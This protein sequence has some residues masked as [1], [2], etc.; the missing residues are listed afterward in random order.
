[1]PERREDYPRII[2]R[3]EQLHV[4]CARMD[5]RQAAQLARLDKING[6]I[7]E[8]W[9]AVGTMRAR[10]SRLERWRSALIG[11]WAALVSVLGAW[12]RIER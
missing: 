4:L 7:G 11:A 12:L 10:I 9:G 2:E 8:L 6:S 5:E 1:M 3:L